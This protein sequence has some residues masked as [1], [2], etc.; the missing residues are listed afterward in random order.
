MDGEAELQF[1]RERWTEREK[2]FPCHFVD[3]GSTLLTKES[4]T[5]TVAAGPHSQAPTL[6]LG[7]WAHALHATSDAARHIPF[8]A[9]YSSQAIE[10]AAGD[11]ATLAAWFDCAA[12]V[13]RPG[14]VLFGIVPD[15]AQ[16]WSRAQ[17][18]LMGESAAGAAGVVT[19]DLF[20]LTFDRGVDEFVRFGTR[21]ALT[22]QDGGASHST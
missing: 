2:P 15:S 4:S 12:Q 11:E 8:D 1:A 16:M 17:K 21:F 19:G 13:L 10:N 7:D 22:L 5:S 20:E 18:I 9:V 6:A 14:G 3:A